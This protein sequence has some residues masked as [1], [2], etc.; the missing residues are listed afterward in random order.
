MFIAIRLLERAERIS[1][2][3]VSRS[4]TVAVQRKEKRRIVA[5]IETTSCFLVKIGLKL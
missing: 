4:T 3:K 2:C 1:Q 5:H